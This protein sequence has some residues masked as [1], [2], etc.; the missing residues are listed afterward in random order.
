LAPGSSPASR[1]QPKQ[2]FVR[3]STRPICDFG[4]LIFDMQLY[5]AQGSLQRQER[6]YLGV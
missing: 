1:I 4:R 3:G 6:Q 5:S 2:H